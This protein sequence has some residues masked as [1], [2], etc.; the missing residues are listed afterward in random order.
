MKILVINGPNLN[1]IGKR[2]PSI[3]GT[4]TYAALCSRI[5]KSAEEADAYVEI[6]QSNSEGEIVSKIQEAKGVFDGLVVNGGALTHYSYA[7][8]DAVKYADLPAV[9]VHISNIFKRE[10]FRKHSVLSPICVG[11]VS[12]LGIEGYEYAINYLVRIYKKSRKETLL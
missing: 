9:E 11:I 2:E 3:Y 1:V 5:K 10:E 7:L 6:F 12:G 4:V 8:Y